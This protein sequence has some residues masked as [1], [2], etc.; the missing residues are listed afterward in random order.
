MKI[1][2]ERHYAHRY[3]GALIGA[4]VSISMGGIA[5]WLLLRDLWSHGTPEQGIGAFLFVF[6]VI[7]VVGLFFYAGLTLAYG[8]ITNR[9]DILAI[10]SEGVSHFGKFVKWE[11]IKWL[12]YGCKRKGEMMLFYQKKG[13]GFDRYLPVTEPISEGEIAALFQELANDVAPHHKDLRIG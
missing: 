13:L 8:W 5:L 4:I 6:P 9:I 3:F 7:G 10:T 1:Y 11:E 2:L 12:S